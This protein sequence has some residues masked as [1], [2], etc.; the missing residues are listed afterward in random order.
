MNK[1]LEQL[2]ED[3][4]EAIKNEQDLWDDYTDSTYITEHAQK[5]YDDKL[6]E[7]KAIDNQTKVWN[8]ISYFKRKQHNKEKK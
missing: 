6:N 3:L 1:T 5:A 2:N 7:I 8:N 4:N